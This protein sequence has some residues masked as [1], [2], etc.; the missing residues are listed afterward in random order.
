MAVDMSP[1]ARLTRF[2]QH[3]EKSKLGDVQKLLN[4]CGGSD[5]NFEQLMSMLVNKYGPE[6]MVS[7]P[8]GL[9]RRIRR[10]YKHYNPSKLDTVDDLVKRTKKKA[11]YE[12]RLMGMLIDKYGEEPDGEFSEEEEEVGG[13]GASLSHE[14][15][16]EEDDEEEDEDEDENDGDEEDPDKSDSDFDNEE[17]V[18]F[19]T[20]LTR[21]YEH[22][23]PAKVS[24]VPKLLAKTAG[25]WQNEEKL[26]AMMVKKYGPEPDGQPKK[27]SDDGANDD[28][29]DAP[30]PD[31]KPAPAE[32]GSQGAEAG[33][34][35]GAG[36]TSSDSALL[37]DIIYCPADGLPPEY[38]EYLPSFAQALPWLESNCPDLVLTTKKGM[39]VKEFMTNGGG[40]EAAD[41]KSSS[42]RGGAGA[43]NK[44]FGGAGK[45]KTGEVTIELSKRQ[46]RKFVTAVVGLDAFG[47]KLKEASKAMGKKF[48][49]GASVNKLPD[50]RQSIDI[51]GDYIYDLPDLI[52]ELYPNVEKSQVFLINNG[53]KTKAF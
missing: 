29:K 34:L 2:Y 38:S 25:V 20:R 33:A 50:G 31:A 23:A 32:P 36:T 4:K 3:Y 42:K 30:M 24:D 18:S 11:K 53:K 35:G 17:L 44:N 45:Q 51:Q 19:E 28:A 37:R 6:P 1:R 8:A 12:L 26:M 14:Q 5:K 43:P 7:D 39:T 40:A 46:K 21:F 48:A 41:A 22:Y 49:C 13:E 16:N 10:F 47:I 15:D 52:L 9:R 27:P